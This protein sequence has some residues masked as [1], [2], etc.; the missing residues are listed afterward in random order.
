MK[1]IKHKRIFF[2]RSGII[3]MFLHY[4]SSSCGDVA[5]NNGYRLPSDK[6]PSRSLMFVMDMISHKY[7]LLSPF[8]LTIVFS[9]ALLSDRFYVTYP[10][11]IKH[12][13]G[14]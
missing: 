5:Q 1:I 6:P 4:Y 2:P 3:I 10:R 8:T 11:R 9:F 14:E 13:F 7:T 12:M